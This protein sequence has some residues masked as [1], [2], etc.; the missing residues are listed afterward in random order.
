LAILVSACQL[1]TKDQLSEEIL[2]TGDKIHEMYNEAECEY[3]DFR[4]KHGEWIS[5]H[6]ADPAARDSTHLAIEERHNQLI[7]GYYT[8][9]QDFRKVIAD[10]G[11]LNKTV[12]TPRYDVTMAQADFDSLK[13]RISD[14]EMMYDAM[15]KAHANIASDHNKT[16]PECDEDET[17]KTAPDTQ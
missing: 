9:L 14:M 15:Q 8:F 1:D 13:V 6:H 7:E 12:H 5:E 17:A 3:N 16:K 11:E 10:F 4:E 2:Q